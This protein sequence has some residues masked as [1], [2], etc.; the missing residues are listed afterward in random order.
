MDIFKTIIIPAAQQAAAQ[1][2]EPGAFNT[3]LSSDGNAPA[4][5]FISSGYIPEGDVG[6]LTDL[7]GADVSE[8]DPYI[9]MARLGL[10]LVQAPLAAE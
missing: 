9:A 7:P 6:P 8:E 2:I 1:G 5:H 4:T 10:Q 3:G